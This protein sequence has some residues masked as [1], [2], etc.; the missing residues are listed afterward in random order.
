M[1]QRLVKLA[2]LSRGR[3]SL[4]RCSPDWVQGIPPEYKSWLR[5]AAAPAGLGFAALRLACC[6][7]FPLRGQL[8]RRVEGALGVQDSEV[9]ARVGAAVPNETAREAAREWYRRYKHMARREEPSVS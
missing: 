1:K 9:W 8:A 5:E 3:S 6:N 2:R 4:G 7:K